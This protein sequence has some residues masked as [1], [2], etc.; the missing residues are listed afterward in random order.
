M[1]WHGMVWYGMGDEDGIDGEG[2]V[3]LGS[4]DDEEVD[5]PDDA[6]RVEV[7]PP[8]LQRCHQVVAAYRV[9]YVDDDRHD[10]GRDGDEEPP[11]RPSGWIRDG[12][13]EDWVRGGEGRSSCGT[14]SSG[15]RRRPFASGRW[16]APS[17]RAAPRLTWRPRNRSH[18][19]RVRGAGCAAGRAAR[20]AAPRQ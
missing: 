19:A 3:H 5:Q 18:A 17:E 20:R 15:T 11:A 7:A 12:E 14:S 1:V 13:P 4:G 2:E 16:A 10:E 9:E 8:H 6:R